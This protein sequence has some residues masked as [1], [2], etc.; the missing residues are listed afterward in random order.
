MFK[1]LDEADGEMLT[2]TIDGIETPAEVG[3]TL[4]AVILRQD[5]CWTRQTALSGT[6]RAPYCMMGVC[7]ECLAEVDGV[8]SVQTCLTTVSSGMRIVRQVGKRRVG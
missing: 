2:V 4:A 8:V 6:R 7:Y 5:P 3:E 1:K